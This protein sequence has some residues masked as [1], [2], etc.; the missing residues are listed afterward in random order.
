MLEYNEAWSG[1]AQ[2]NPSSCWDAADYAFLLR[3]SS[4]GRLIRLARF[5]PR[6]QTPAKHDLLVYLEDVV[7]DAS[8]FDQAAI[9]DPNNPI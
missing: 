9:P 7:S 1:L 2:R 3:S 8:T 6:P 4:D 5:T